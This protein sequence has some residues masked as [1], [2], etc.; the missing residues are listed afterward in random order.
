[1]VDWLGVE[2]QRGEVVGQKSGWG[3]SRWG[4]RGRV[5]GVEW[6]AVEQLRI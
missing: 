6:L 2:W 1:M 4:Q 5:V 3:T